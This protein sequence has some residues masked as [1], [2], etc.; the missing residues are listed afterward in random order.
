MS[1]LTVSQTLLNSTVAALVVQTRAPDGDLVC[2]HGFTQNR[3]AMINNLV[4]PFAAH[5]RRIWFVDCPGHGATTVDS[6]TPHS[7]FDALCTIG[8]H[9]DIFGYSMGGRLGLWLLSLYPGLITNAVIASAHLGLETPEAQA[10]R[11]ASDGQLADRLEHLPYS[12]GLGQQNQEFIAFL[13]EWNQ[14]PLFGGRSL[15]NSE[16]RLRA[17]NHPDALASA[18]RTY[19][20]GEQPNLTSLLS[21]TKTRLLYLYGEHDTVYRAMAER[22]RG[23][24]TCEVRMI[25]R[26]AHDVLHD[27]PSAVVQLATQFLS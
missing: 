21:E 18:L 15:T 3:F 9:F 19:G 20:T 10:A 14:A 8:P 13:E 4:A 6:R 23:L 7:F 11:R 1:A 2:L 24:G 5:Y 22:A 25:D 12:P 27:Q 26:G 16:L 17:S